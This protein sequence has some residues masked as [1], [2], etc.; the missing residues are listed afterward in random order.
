[1]IGSLFPEDPAKGDYFGT[2]IAI[3]GDLVI[4]GAVFDDDQG[5]SS[6]S[7]YVFDLQTGEQMRKFVASD[8]V[9]GDYFG[10]AVDIEGNLC[11]IGAPQTD[12]DAP[13]RAYAFEIDSGLECHIFVSDDGASGDCFGQTV[14]LNDTVVAIGACQDDDEEIDCGSVYLFDCVDGEQL[15]ELH[16]SDC[17]E[18]A[19]F[20]RS[21]SM[22]GNLL[23]IGSG[24]LDQRGGVAYIFDT[25]T[26]TELA[27]LVP[28][29]QH[30]DDNFGRAVAISGSHLLIGAYL[31]DDFGTD[32]GSAYFFRQYGPSN[33][34]EV[35]PMPLRSLEDGLF[36]MHFEQANER[37]WLLYSVTGLRPTYI[38]HLQIIVELQEPKLGFGPR[39][40]NGDGD[41]V[42]SLPIPGVAYPVEIWFQGV[43]TNHATNS[44]ATIIVPVR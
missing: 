5:I 42:L 44:V 33:F 27:R 19:F 21:L 3:D 2:S 30:P 13:G 12:S 4:I 24:S 39:R 17:A 10:G 7:A 15:A 25:E 20:G 35:G 34:L 36:E 38:R 14:A 8:G 29:D 31:D 41:L 6:G 11:V 28:F 9:E 18:G 43:Q 23:L 40:T 26:E 37:T 22:D 32:A 1:M 16:A